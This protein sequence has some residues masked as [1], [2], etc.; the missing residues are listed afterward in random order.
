M[1]SGERE[2]EKKN[3]GTLTTATAA[4]ILILHVETQITPPAMNMSAEITL[5][6][7]TK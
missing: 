7:S 5:N 6:D 1:M 3:A 2:R 4:T